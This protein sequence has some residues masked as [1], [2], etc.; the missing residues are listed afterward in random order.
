MVQRAE[1]AEALQA[2]VRSARARTRVAERELL[3]AARIVEV[4]RT[5]LV[6]ALRDRRVVEGRQKQ[7]TLARELL[8]E[9]RGEEADEEAHAAGRRSGS[10][11]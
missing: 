7:Q 1:H 4:R 2:R 8:E 10:R 9:Q 6:E 11:L 3:E 5:A